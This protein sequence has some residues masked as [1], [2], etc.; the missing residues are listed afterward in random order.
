MEIKAVLAGA[1][2]WIREARSIA[3]PRSHIEEYAL[4][5]MLYASLQNLLDAAAMLLVELG[6]RKPSSYAD[7]GKVLSEAGFKIDV[8]SFKL[9]AATRN[10]LAHAY[11]RPS[12][13]DLLSIVKNVLPPA[14]SLI[15]SLEEACGKAGADPSREI[16]G[17]ESVFERW[18]VV[19]AYLFG[20]RV[21]GI[22]REESDYDIAVLFNRSVTVMEEIKLAIEISDILK[23]PA[24]RI[25]VIALDMADIVL[26]A[27]VL[28]EGKLIYVREREA[29]REWEKR[30]YLEI[31]Y[32]TDLN[33]VYINR[34]LH[35]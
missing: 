21:R 24:D 34:K 13:K 9:I 5:W 30:T 25:D 31:L 28:E 32:S 33:A 22:L 20:S 17:V 4:R 2:E 1:L 19:A 11:R 15:S 8:Y 14:E 3:T 6:L 23:V 7:I 29:L 16:H 10:F 26:K 35:R 12:S 27:R 18:G